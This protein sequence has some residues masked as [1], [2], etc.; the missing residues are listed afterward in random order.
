MEWLKDYV[1]EFEGVKDILCSE[2]IV[3]PFDTM[4]PTKLLTDASR[5][6]CFGYAPVQTNPLGHTHLVQWGVV[7]PHAHSTYYATVQLE[8]NTIL[9][10]KVQLLS[11]RGFQVFWL[12]LN[13]GLS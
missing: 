11:V 10:A 5:D 6:H 12:S 9:W 13:M 4:L 1:R 2:A 7:F 3:Q 8:A